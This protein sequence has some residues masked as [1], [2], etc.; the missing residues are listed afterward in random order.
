MAAWLAAGVAAWVLLAAA[1]SR[2]EA[3][4]LPLALEREAGLFGPLWLRPAVT[5]L[6][7]AAVALRPSYPYGFT[8]PVAL[9]QDWAIG[10]DAAALAAIVAWRL[11]AV[12][13]TVPRSGELFLLAFLG[14]AVLAPAWAFR[15]EGHPGNEPKY[16]RQAVA[17]G[18]FG[19][20][21]A[22]GVS[23]A[24]EELPARGAGEVLAT[25]ARTFAARVAA[26]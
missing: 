8:L 6:A 18:L 25:A 7:L 2:R 26:P 10:Q 17:L 21:D 3:V 20:F 24:M 11:P 15:W 14:Y 1:R 9:T 19:S 23:A 12:R 16:L 22:E 13:W 5:L 4:A